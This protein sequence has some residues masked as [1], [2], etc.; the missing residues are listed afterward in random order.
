MQQMGTMRRFRNAASKAWLGAALVVS[1][2]LAESFAFAHELDA[3]A[4]DN[5]QVCAVCVGAASLGA[6]A[7]AVPF[8]FE[9]VIAVTAIVITVLVA[10]SSVIPNR[11]Y[12]RGPPAV[13]F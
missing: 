1:M 4:H 8:H 12:A 6:G 3:A 9:P 10:L 11:R 13:S 2:L 5:G 7:V